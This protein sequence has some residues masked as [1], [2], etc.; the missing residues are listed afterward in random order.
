MISAE[1]ADFVVEDA[2]ED[3]NKPDLSEEEARAAS[4]ELSFW[5][6]ENSLGEISMAVSA[7]HH[8]TTEVYK[9]RRSAMVNGG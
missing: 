3:Q 8:K 4:C 5:G 1:A 2:E 9:R 7:I 6:R